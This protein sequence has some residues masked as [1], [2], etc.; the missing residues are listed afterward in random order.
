MKKLGV[1]EVGL[2]IETIN[3][4]TQKTIRKHLDINT[5]PPAIKLLRKY[6][7]KIHVSMQL[8]LPGESEEDATNTFEFIKNLKTDEVGIFHTRLQPGT[9]LYTNMNS[10]EHNTSIELSKF[11]EC[12]TVP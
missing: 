12:Q 8:G 4:K 5:I 6:H 10:Y 11:G 7:M 3:P 1:R 2:G 9:E